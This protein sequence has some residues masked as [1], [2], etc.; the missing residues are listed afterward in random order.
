[1]KKILVVDHDKAITDIIRRCLS[2]KY[3]IETENSGRKALEII[4][5]I[6]FDLIISDVMMPDVDGIALLSFMK[7]TRI[8]TPVLIMSG[9]PIGTQFFQ[10]ATILGAVE[11][12][13][14]PFTIEALT[15]AVEKV[16]G[17]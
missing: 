14:K 15:L 17:E 1:M 5:N 11:T 12:L 2:K 8:T 7:K 16:L 13:Q 10:A 3:N 4:Q 6:D 9:H